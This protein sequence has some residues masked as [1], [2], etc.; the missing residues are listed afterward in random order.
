MDSVHVNPLIERSIDIPETK[1]SKAKLELRSRVL[2][3]KS[4]EVGVAGGKLYADLSTK[5]SDNFDAIRSNVE[6][7]IEF[8]ELL[9][10][11]ITQSFAL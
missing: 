1:I 6:G 9:V 11:E 4:S 7:K 3:F 10:S 5:I 2:A 8:E